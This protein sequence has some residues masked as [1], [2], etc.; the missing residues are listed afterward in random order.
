MS[1]EAFV[2]DLEALVNKHKVRLGV[3]LN[4]INVVD[5]DKKTRLEITDEIEVWTGS[6]KSRAHGI[7][8]FINI[9]HG[10]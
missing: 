9:H 2:K 6:H 4:H 10:E 1:I 3:A 5:S 7:G 8:S